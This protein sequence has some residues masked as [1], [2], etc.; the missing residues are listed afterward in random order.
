[1]TQTVRQWRVFAAAQA[2]RPALAPTGWEGEVWVWDVILIALTLTNAQKQN[3]STRSGQTDICRCMKNK[4]NTAQHTHA[5]MYSK[6]TK[7]Y[8]KNKHGFVSI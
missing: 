6:K 7:Q 8:N 3:I 2:A 5:R 1:M 4:Q